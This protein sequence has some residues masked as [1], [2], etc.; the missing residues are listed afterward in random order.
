MLGA[1]GWNS[2]TTR[3]SRHK[4]PRRWRFAE[5]ISRTVICLPS[6]VSNQVSKPACCCHCWFQLHIETCRWV[7]PVWLAKA[8]SHSNWW[9]T[10]VQ[11][12]TIFA[13]GSSHLYLLLCLQIWLVIVARLPSL[14]ASYQQQLLFGHTLW[15]A[16]AGRPPHLSFAG[17]CSRVTSWLASATI[18]PSDAGKL[19]SSAP[20]RRPPCTSA[21]MCKVVSM[22]PVSSL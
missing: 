5:S 18:K 11:A 9:K 6:T 17:A 14:Q 21:A 16:N 12:I 2:L 15:H 19:S 4:F 20:C 10:A 8:M 1:R 22:S 3:N 13:S 7:V